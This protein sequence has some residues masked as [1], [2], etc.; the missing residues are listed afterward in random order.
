[1]QTA[2]YSFDWAD[3]PGVSNAQNRSGLAAGDYSVTVTDA[4]GCFST[5]AFTLDAATG[6]TGITVCKSDGAS[7]LSVDPDP[8]N[9][10]YTWTI[11]SIASPLTSYTSKISSGVGTPSIT[12]DWTTVPIGGYVVT[13]IGSNLSCGTSAPSTM[14]V[15]VQAPTATATA[16][17]ACEGSNLNLHASGGSTYSWAGPN[18]FCQSGC[19]SDNL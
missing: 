3:I 7:V 8:A 17:L 10:T 14:V 15:Y 4:N 1:M 9:T 19:E 13:V 6:C 12:V 11:E 18:G 16:D 2:P 5:S